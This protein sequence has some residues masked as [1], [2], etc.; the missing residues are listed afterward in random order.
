MLKKLVPVESLI[1]GFKRG[2]CQV[3]FLMFFCLFPVIFVTQW[4][5]D[6]VALKMYE[7]VESTIFE[8]GG[9]KW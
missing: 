1:T 8:L 7:A 3:T 5:V 9:Y 4:Q 2:S 6:V